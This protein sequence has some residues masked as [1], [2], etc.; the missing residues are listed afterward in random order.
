MNWPAALVALL[1]I[2]STGY[3]GLAAYVWVR[4]SVVGSRPL[5]VMLLAVKVWTICYALELSCRTVEAARWWS[6]LKYVGVVA[7]PPALW[8]FVLQYT[9]RGRLRRGVLAA[10][11]VEPVLVLGA[12]AIPDQRV[13]LQIY[14]DPP[15]HLLGAPVPDSGGPWFWVHAGYTYVLMLGAVFYLMVQ[16]SRVAHAYRRQGMVLIA[17]SLTPFVGNLLFNLGWLGAG[18]PDPTVVLF[19]LTAVVLVWG[20]FRLRLLD[21]V[22]VARGALLEQMSDGVLLLDAYGRVI[23]ANPAGESMLAVPHGQL[24]GR[25]AADLLPGLSPVISVRGARNVPGTGGGLPAA[26]AH[27]EVRL[28]D[29]GPDAA[30]PGRDLSVTVT[31]VTDPAGRQTAQLLVL[32]DITDRKRTER[33]VRELLDEQTQVSQTFRQTLRP[34]SLPEVPGLRLVARSIPA[35]RGGGVSGDFYDVHPAGAGR[36]AFVLGDVSGRGVQAA[37]V[38]SMARYTVRTLSSQGWSPREVLD[39]LNRAMLATDD[40]ERFCTVVYGQVVA[41]GPGVRLVLALGGHPQPLL[42]RRDATVEPVGEPGTALGLLATIDVH[43]VSVELASG[44]LLLAYTDGVTEARRQR[45]QFGEERLAK[46]LADSGGAVPAGGG[47]VGHQLAGEL[48]AD[49]ADGVIAAVEAFAQERD[50]MALLVL[51]VP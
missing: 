24:V 36:S 15:R 44:D 48:A 39:Q 22:P 31:S 28:P 49:V 32:Q 9:G 46:V 20:F 45:E 51:A 29:T 3:S 23:D 2:G 50:D 26:P 27:R 13:K 33:R 11:L 41:D 5:V 19:G 14:G 7:L 40:L 25:S 35:G 37:V 4:R 30:I 10:L 6:A 34:A 8:S 43:E 38:T 42:R 18:T 21:L 12:L 1:L 17:A 16:L 47:P